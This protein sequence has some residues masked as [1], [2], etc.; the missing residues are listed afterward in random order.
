MF[1]SGREVKQIYRYISLQT[2]NVNIELISKEKIENYCIWQKIKEFIQK[3]DDAKL[4]QD[5]QNYFMYTSIT[6]DY[7]IQLYQKRYIASIFAYVHPSISSMALFHDFLCVLRHYSHMNRLYTI[8]INTY[9]GFVILVYP[10]Q[11]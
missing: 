7:K 10:K 3:K 1:N 11:I 2:L 9:G 5:K 6:L 4:K 8:H